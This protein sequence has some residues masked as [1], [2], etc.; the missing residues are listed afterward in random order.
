MAVARFETG[1]GSKLYAYRQSHQQVYAGSGSDRSRY[2]VCSRIWCQRA[3]AAAVIGHYG[4][5][6]YGN[7]QITVGQPACARPHTIPTPSPV[8]SH[9]PP[10]SALFCRSSTVPVLILKPE[11]L[12][13]ILKG[14]KL[15]EIRSKRLDKYVGQELYLAG[16]LTAAISGRARLVICHGPLSKNEWKSNFE[17]H[18]VPSGQLLHFGST[19]RDVRPYGAK[20]YAWELG[21]VE[22]AQHRISFTRNAAVITQNVTLQSWQI[23]AAQFAPVGQ[24]A[25]PFS[26]PLHGHNSRWDRLLTRGSELGS[27]STQSEF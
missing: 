6:H 11:W 8:H 10:P 14:E 15:W 18:K 25:E 16:S 22:R 20:T 4:N 2:T 19:S 23:A 13:L 27:T 3:A 1:A 17:L 12:E 26:P 24:S 7:R 21:S 9:S 5:G